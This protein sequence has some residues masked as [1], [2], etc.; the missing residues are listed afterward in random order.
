MRIGILK[1]KYPALFKTI[2]SAIGVLLQFSTGNKL[3]CYFFSTSLLHI[4]IYLDYPTS[5]S[6]FFFSVFIRINESVH[7]FFPINYM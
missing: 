3:T 1:Q 7:C 6:N 2:L 5:F 4:V